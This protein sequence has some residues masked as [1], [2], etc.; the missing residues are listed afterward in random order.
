[1]RNPATPNITR[2][3]RALNPS[4]ERA[5]RWDAT[6]EEVP[7]S[8]ILA[9]R[10]DY[11]IWPILFPRF[12]RY[13]LS[14]LGHLS[15]T[16]QVLI[17]Q[18]FYKGSGE[19]ENVLRAYVSAEAYK[20]RGARATDAIMLAQISAEATHQVAPTDYQ[21]VAAMLLQAPGCAQLGQ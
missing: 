3:T 2:C 13:E 16:E 9:R 10:E 11:S 1:M 4:I 14:F 19:I 15:V 8:A 12:R 7:G 6:V 18:Y 17:E 20:A 5:V 21:R